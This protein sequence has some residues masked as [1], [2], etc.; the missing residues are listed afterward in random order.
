[1]GVIGG[2]KQRSVSGETAKGAIGRNRNLERNR[3]EEIKREGKNWNKKTNVNY[4]PTEY[5][6]P[7][8]CP[9]VRLCVRVV[10]H[11]K[12]RGGYKERDKEQMECDGEIKEHKE[13]NYSKEK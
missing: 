13:R 9:G 7:Q 10:I 2:A 5:L 6:A 11:G 4:I 8:I 3:K 12:T 1:M